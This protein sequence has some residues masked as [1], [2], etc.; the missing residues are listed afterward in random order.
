MKIEIEIIDYSP[1][2]G[3]Q[4]KWDEGHKIITQISNGVM[5]IRANQSGLLT[6][7]RHILTLSQEKIP[8]HSH[9]HFDDYGGLE[10]GS[11]ELI[12]QKISD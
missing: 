9:W 12:I 1:K 3:I 7:A 2:N 5:I 11:C 4:T 8:S 6:L 10:D